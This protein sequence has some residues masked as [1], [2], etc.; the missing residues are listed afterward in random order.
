MLWLLALVPMGVAAVVMAVRPQRRA[1]LALVSGFGLAATGLLVPI[2]ASQGW[3]GSLAWSTALTLRASL[4]PLSALVAALVPAVAIAV[5][6]YA[7]YQ[8]RET[9]RVRLIGLLLFF[10]GAMELLVIADDLLTVLIGWELVGACSWALIAHEWRDLANPR[11]AM[12]AFVMTR[13]GDLGLFIAA[14]AAYAGAGSFAYADLARLD[15]THL[16]IVAFGVLFS[17]ASKSGQLPFS[18]W[19]F[20][21]MRGPSSVSALL[22]AATMVAAGAYL[23]ARL[24]PML[25]PVGGFGPAVMAIGLATALG[26][27]VV[28]LLQADVKKVLAASTSAH[29]GLMFVAIGAGFPGIA[30]LH[31][32]AHGFLKALLFL[33]AGVA[34]DRSGSHELSDMRL[35]R[36]LP[37]VAALAAVGAAALAGL[38]PLGAAWTKDAIVATA[39]AAGPGWA[40]G[41]V[42]AGALSAAYAT[43]WLWLAYGFGQGGGSD[44]NKASPDRAVVASLGWLAFASAA[45]SL[46]WFPDVVSWLDNRLS[47]TLPQESASLIGAALVAVAAGALLGRLI[48]QRFPKLGHD[49][50][51][52]NVADWW[53]LPRLIELA[54]TRPVTGLAHASARIDDRVV[55]AVPRAVGRMGRRF[56]GVLAVLDTRVVDRGVRL[57]T[58]FVAWL[59]RATSRIGE[60]VADGI[61]FGPAQLVALGGDDARRLQTGLSHHALAVLLLGALVFGAILFAVGL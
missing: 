3:T 27:G 48:A 32:I 43:R 37:V 60:R 44:Q 40:A 24:Q 31:L 10:C 16:S 5:L 17:A 15:A 57:T 30:V 22:H 19:L 12:Y 6:V 4:T 2:A 56:A 25:V 52:A 51:P 11:A 50:A 26:G 29:F 9:G 58:T 42:V 7:C 28:A 13:F 14:L 61:A 8:E 34:I 54:V 41:G 45:L 33:A 23:L 46:L 39:A 47:L 20:R 38:P 35:G 18:P 21:A 55:D 53:Q 59:A 36:A 49:R 1:A